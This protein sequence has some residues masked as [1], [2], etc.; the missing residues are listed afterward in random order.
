MDDKLSKALLDAIN[1]RQANMGSS[2]MLDGLVRSGAVSMPRRSSGSMN[3]SPG[4]TPRGYDSI[5]QSNPVSGWDNETSA[6]AVG[7]TIGNALYGLADGATLGLIDMGVKAA[8]WDDDLQ[9]ILGDDKLAQNA[10]MFG[11]V[12]SI[13]IPYAGVAK[14]GRAAAKGIAG[15]KTGMGSTRKGISES[16]ER[17]FK[18]RLESNGSVLETGENLSDVVRRMTGDITSKKNQY[19]GYNILQSGRN[20]GKDAMD[21]I[22]KTYDDAMRAPLEKILGADNKVIDE[23]ITEAF[24]FVTKADGWKHVNSIEQLMANVFFKKFGRGPDATKTAKVIAG[25]A[26]QA[27]QLFVENLGLMTAQNMVN[28]MDR[29]V[30][31]DSYDLDWGYNEYG[32]S[33]FVGLEGME[34]VKQALLLGTLGSAANRIAGGLDKKRLTDFWDRVVRPNLTKS[35]TNK[36]TQMAEENLERFHNVLKYKMDDPI[37]SGISI[38]WLEHAGVNNL[39]ALRS[40]I[41]N[42]SLTKDQAMGM[43]KTI[44]SFDK[45]VRQKNRALFVKDTAKDLVGSAPRVITDGILNYMF[46]MPDE[47]KN[48]PENNFEFYLDIMHGAFLAKA[49]GTSMFDVGISNKS[50]VMRDT[51]HNTEQTSRLYRALVETYD[52]NAVKVDMIVGAQ[53]NRGMVSMLYGKLG[54]T[55]SF[56]SVANIFED[57]VSQKF[58]DAIMESSR[59]VDAREDADLTP[60]ER[61]QRER[62]DMTVAELRNNSQSNYDIDGDP[63]YHLVKT[64]WDY[65]GFGAM[66][67]KFVEG[68]ATPDAKSERATRIREI[69]T[70]NNGIPFDVDML[71]KTEIKQIADQIR[72]VK[73]ERVEGNKTT[74]TTLG[75]YGDGPS[76]FME[77]T[78]DGMTHVKETYKQNVIDMVTELNTYIKGL[79][80]K[81]DAG[82][83]GFDFA[84]EQGQLV[85]YAPVST[86]KDMNY[87]GAISAF[88]D[89]L[90]KLHENNIIR[91]V[92]SND[93]TRYR[94]GTAALHGM[95]KSRNALDQ[96]D[97]MII[98]G[99]NKIATEL[100]GGPDSPLANKWVEGRRE[101]GGYVYKS[102]TPFAHASKDNVF[103]SFYSD[104]KRA[105]VRENMYQLVKGQ[106]T[107]SVREVNSAINKT[108]SLISDQTQAKRIISPVNIELEKTDAINQD[109][110]EAQNMLADLQTLAFITGEIRDNGEYS[111]ETQSIKIE[112]LANW[113]EEYTKSGMKDMVDRL[114]VDADGEGRLVESLRLEIL[115]RMMV[116]A[117]MNPMQLA[118][119]GDLLKSRAGYL[120]FGQGQTGIG[121]KQIHIISEN[122]YKELLTKEGISGDAF[123][124]AVKS[125]TDVVG[126]LSGNNKGKP[127]VD[128]VFDDIVAVRKR[129][130]EEQYGSW[131]SDVINVFTN[132]RDMHLDRQRSSDVMDMVARVDQMKRDLGDAIPTRRFGDLFDGL[133]KSLKDNDI[134]GAIQKTEEISRFSSS[135]LRHIDTSNKQHIATIEKFVEEVNASLFELQTLKEDLYSGFMEANKKREGEGRTFLIESEITNQH[136]LNF[137]KDE[138]GN[139]TDLGKRFERFV[140]GQGAI[141][142]IPNSASLEVFNKSILPGLDRFQ[143]VSN[144][145]KQILSSFGSHGSIV[146]RIY[147]DRL[148]GELE[149][150]VGE[151]A[152]SKELKLSSLLQIAIQKSDPE[153]FDNTVK[154][155]LKFTLESSYTHEHLVE[156]EKLNAAAD[157]VGNIKSSAD[158]YSM[159]SFISR[160]GISETESGI[161]SGGKFTSAFISKFESEYGSAFNQFDGKKSKKTDVKKAEQE[162]KKFEDVLVKAAMEGNKYDK[163]T[164]EGVLRMEIRNKYMNNILKQIGNHRTQDAIEIHLLDVNTEK[165]INYSVTSTQKSKQGTFSRYVQRFENRIP[166]VEGAR[167]VRIFDVSEVA[168]SSSVVDGKPPSTD[169]IDNF[170]GLQSAQDHMRRS[171]AHILDGSKLSK[172]FRNE[173]APGTIKVGDQVYELY[174]SKGRDEWLASLG[175]RIQSKSDVELRN[176]EPGAKFVLVG[177]TPGTTIAFQRTPE[178]IRAMQHVIKDGAED[179]LKGIEAALSQGRIA[180]AEATRAKTTI[181]DFFQHA[182]MDEN[183]FYERMSS[184][185]EDLALS[186]ML[187]GIY[188]YD[189]EPSVMIRAYATKATV[190]EANQEVTRFSKYAQTVE[191][192]A[193]REVNDIQLIHLKN[194]R[195]ADDADMGSYIDNLMTR[196][197]RIAVFAD[198]K[199][200]KGNDYDG[201]VAITTRNNVMRNIDAM[202]DIAIGDKNDA[203]EIELREYKAW[204]DTKE[205]RELLVS[206]D[207]SSVN[208]ATYMSRRMAD[209]IFGVNGYSRK[210]DIGGTKGV[211]H[212]ADTE[213]AYTMIGKQNF[214]YDA[215]V[216]ELMEKSG[217][218]FIMGESAAKEFTMGKQKVY[219]GLENRTGR[220]WL[221]A[222]VNNAGDANIANI[223]MSSVKVSYSKIGKSAPLTYSL[224]NFM[225][226]AMIRDFVAFSGIESA[227]VDYTKMMTD[228]AN[229]NYSGIEQARKIMNELDIDITDP[230]DLAAAVVMLQAKARTNNPAVMNHIMTKLTSRVIE[231]VSGIRKDSNKERGLARSM[232]LRPAFDA[233]IT[234][235]SRNNAKDGDRYIKHFGGMNA[236]HALGKEA[237]NSIEDLTFVYEGKGQDYGIT[238]DTKTSMW[239]VMDPSVRSSDNMINKNDKRATQE[240]KD[241]ITALESLGS[242]YKSVYSEAA[243][244]SNYAELFTG[245]MI[246]VHN[247]LK[248]ARNVDRQIQD[249]VASSFLDLADMGTAE[250]ERSKQAILKILRGNKVSIAAQTVRIPRKTASDVRLTKI[251]RFLSEQDGNVAEIN[252]LDLT[253]VHQG[254]FDVDTIN[255]YFGLPASMQSQYVLNSAL[256]LDTPAFPETKR[257]SMDVFNTDNTQR[258]AGM[259]AKQDGMNDFRETKRG[260]SFKIGQIAKIQKT[261]T[262]I[263]SM[264]M[265]FSGITTIN[266][267]D[268]EHL[269]AFNIRLGIALQSAVDDWKNPWEALQDDKF[270]DMLLFNDQLYNRN[271]EPIDMRNIE[272]ENNGDKFRPLFAKENGVLDQVD[273]DI[274]RTTY[275]NVAKMQSPFRDSYEDGEKVRWDYNRLRMLRD[276]TTAFMEDP[277]KKVFL[278]LLGRYRATNDREGIRLLIDKFIPE[279][280]VI[281]QSEI[282][283]VL[284]DPFAKF[285]KV[286]SLVD[287]YSFTDV[288]KNVNERKR[289]VHE[290]L[291]GTPEGAFL[292]SFK[293]VVVNN[294]DAVKD[295][296][297]VR[298]AVTKSNE[299][300][301]SIDLAFRLSP[302]S[303]VDI[304]NKSAADADAINGDDVTQSDAMRMDTSILDDDIKT[305]SR[306]NDLES[307]YDIDAD[308]GEHVYRRYVSIV[309]TVLKE[310][311]K[312]RA[313]LEAEAMGYGAMVNA[314]DKQLSRAEY[315]LDVMMYHGDAYDVSRYMNRINVLKLM[316]RDMYNRRLR[317]AGMDEETALK[318][319]NVVYAGKKG[320]FI[321]SDLKNAKYVYRITKQALISED[322][323]TALAYV[324]TV[325]PGN[326]AMR[327]KPGE[328]IVQ[329][330]PLMINGSQS[331]ESARESA[332]WERATAWSGRLQWLAKTEDR[333]RFVDSYDLLTATIKR[334]QDTMMN[335]IQNGASVKDISSQIDSFNNMA[336]GKFIEQFSNGGKN[337]VDVMSY[338]LRPHVGNMPSTNA[339]VY[340]L[341]LFPN[342]KWQKILAKYVASRGADGKGDFEAYK[343][344]MTYANEQFYGVNDTGNIIHDK[345]FE[346]ISAG[347]YPGPYKQKRMYFDFLATTPLRAFNAAPSY[348]ANIFDPNNPSMKHVMSTDGDEYTVFSNTKTSADVTFGNMRFKQWLNETNTECL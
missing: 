244:K 151:G 309:D 152:A 249:Q 223:P 66:T 133:N 141:H 127:Q 232:V 304:I 264:D 164:D 45:M 19:G 230:S 343:H 84:Q 340:G 248:G 69:V 35:S 310:F 290:R 280:N 64:L 181:K 252:P 56:N 262:A 118:T 206:L 274:I 184:D 275:R 311:K 329:D 103:L 135:L 82:Y 105:E 167:E 109:A 65:V 114:R 112:E 142:R 198:E 80:V 31:P 216:A 180:P 16:I 25:F 283:T 3:P 253:T 217:L 259:Q 172:D 42:G 138:V 155:A 1:E 38:N 271:D 100:G 11:S 346:A 115:D 95:L 88:K 225:P 44:D 23:V 242:V 92:D 37:N 93:G 76:I 314:I 94:N 22:R 39:Q 48:G 240:M 33:R 137:A 318:R 338:L 13:I 104:W 125:Y 251:Q 18:N 183:T 238:Y 150:I 153:M 322:P 15:M 306:S 218:D 159:S 102:D 233:D 196:G 139:K 246:D 269:K 17:A 239:V 9:S 295:N 126:V 67:R 293:D 193:A 160:Y 270:L 200:I 110:T 330:K 226:N 319:L 305:E 83:Y 28:R 219:P 313:T 299:I 334:N 177:V 188:I 146:Q 204:L 175:S 73:V 258:G 169:R 185:N 55:P 301:D 203:K 62:E 20:M 174:S 161:I 154:L 285:G 21:M 96:F 78:R 140:E 34:M 166:D 130:G 91:L 158:N 101:D 339:G 197:A 43:A 210:D 207:A 99:L 81:A 27:P 308:A 49:R 254:D 195:F 111:S 163:D 58:E 209:V 257:I 237:I 281:K 282:R 221:D 328:Y 265:G 205:G 10:R 165:H 222:A 190:S 51:Y 300:V 191:S 276:Q 46:I 212:Y 53:N 286:A 176:L 106:G 250:R 224:T 149:G 79:N 148:R 215:R 57:K 121:P 113:H 171:T 344:I 266:L 75:E 279:T 77:M 50:A 297:I 6:G 12:A 36:Y 292:T 132:I 120:V 178:N 247:I 41:T 272:Y 303:A 189:M 2:T 288:I 74:V 227:A 47:L 97:T 336:V 337:V 341:T 236:S 263:K 267:S 342:Y 260:R 211:F 59:A 213:N 170:M 220:D 201:S 307:G 168:K 116:N 5:G 122:A 52:L 298:M 324:G 63:D 24:E 202:I 345:R 331:A 68:S 312:N 70:N 40:K 273:K 278:S 321:A 199:D 327:V 194:S 245:R 86:Q 255:A 71:T 234:V 87:Y 8:G 119:M 143:T 162:L 108:N 228:V 144:S 179:I 145:Y 90:Y 323:E 30:N 61:A 54:E 129:R 261:I 287:S 268:A 117:S 315:E 277:N 192:D 182:Y 157:R 291:R 123:T 316:R 235:Y 136:L 294:V 4:Y 256:I 72:N 332:A 124:E 208:G 147:N 289:S 229:G 32:Q 89:V 156:R 241:V 7:R 173:I 98:S 326:R 320:G 325:Q 187:R 85:V 231:N 347:R 317:I 186:G 348:M 302:S 131:E 134:D 14:V 214:F 107:T 60:D 26:S 296:V 333:M 284:S 335:A 29:R 243:L 128:L